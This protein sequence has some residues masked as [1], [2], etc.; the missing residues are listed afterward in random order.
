VRDIKEAAERLKNATPEELQTIA[1]HDWDM[2]REVAATC[3]AHQHGS[4]TASEQHVKRMVDRFLRWR[5][6]ENFRP[7]CGITFD[8]SKIHPSSWPTG[9]NLIG[10]SEA[11][12]M[13]RHMLELPPKT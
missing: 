11:T 8:K 6:P 2:I 12:D 9:T 7:D 13:V 3:L 5:L 4:V 10:A 1:K